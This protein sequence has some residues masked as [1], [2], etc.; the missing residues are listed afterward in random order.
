[1]APS[2]NTIQSLPSSIEKKS[3]MCYY[4]RLM[5]ARM[6]SKLTQADLTL[7]GLTIGFSSF[8]SSSESSYFLSFMAC[9]IRSRRNE[10]S[11]LVCPGVLLMSITLERSAAAGFF[12][13]DFPLPFF[14]LAVAK[15]RSSGF[16]ASSMTSS[17]LAASC[18]SPS[19]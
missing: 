12:V 14:F 19:S 17:W 6:L 5:K 4:G 13:F 9:S 7:M 1:M 2:G 10:Y 8:T 16:S 3:S 18:F 15:F 11:K